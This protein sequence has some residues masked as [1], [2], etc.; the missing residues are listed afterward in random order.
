MTSLETNFN[1]MTMTAQILGPDGTVLWEY[2]NFRG[3]FLTYYPLVNLQYPDFSESEANLS[4]KIELRFKTLDGIRRTL[5]EK[6]SD[7]LLRDTPEPGVYG[8]L[9]DEMASFFAQVGDKQV[10][11]AGAVDG[12]QQQPAE[13]KQN[14]GKK[15]AD[16]A[17]ERAPSSKSPEQAPLPKKPVATTDVP[18]SSTNE[19]VPATE[20]TR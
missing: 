20:S 7:W 12:K 15:S 6:K 1:F 17:P 19:I 5:E 11:G 13:G 14:P 16:T 4:R 3:R 8:R 9:F 2:P 10:K 18:T